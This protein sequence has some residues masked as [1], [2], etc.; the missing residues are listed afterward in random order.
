MVWKRNDAKEMMVTQ[1]DPAYD[2]LWDA[3]E[4]LIKEIY[5]VHAS[6][7]IWRVVGIN[8]KS[9]H[10][11][12]K[13]YIN[14]SSMLAQRTIVMG[15]ES[16]FERTEKKKKK[17]RCQ[18]TKTASE[19]CCCE[20]TAADPELCSLRGVLALAER[21]PLRQPR[22][23]HVFA[24]KYG[25]PV[26]DDWRADVE[27]VMKKQSKFVAECM[28]HTGRIRNQRF[29][30]LAQPKSG[31]PAYMLPAV[32][33]VEQ[34]MEFAH[35]FHTF[36]SVGF[37]HSASGTPMRESIGHSLLGLLKKRFGIEDAQWDFPE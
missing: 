25:V 21:V 35:D 26:T 11:S 33:H 10:A 30:H 2:A 34:L 36:I 5:M 9:I 15:I 19:L 24:S 20:L 29:A 37:L 27:G 14:F 32:G 6:M 12:G 13:E 17:C 8:V 22:A 31:M 16:I 1:N 4:V 3:S 28:K 7:R 23:Q 18:R